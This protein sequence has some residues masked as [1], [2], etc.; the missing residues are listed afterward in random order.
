MSFLRK[1]FGQNSPQKAS[2]DE[3]PP[4]AP[5]DPANDPNLIRVYDDYGREIFITRNE[6]REKVLVGNIQKAWENPD[7]LYDI[8]LDA[9]N[10]NFRADIL[11]AAEQ[12][13]KIDPTPARGAC[14]W[15]IVL[16]EE[17]RFKEAQAIFEEHLTKHGADGVILTNLAKVYSKSGRGEKAEETLWQGLQIDP[18]QDNGMG[19]YEAIH[20]ERGGEDAGVEALRR[21]AAVPGSWRAYLSLARNALRQKDLAAAL[22]FYREA[23]SRVSPVP[24]DALMQISGDLG[25]NGYLIE[26]VQ[27]ITPLF[28]PEQHGLTVGNNLIKAHFD[29]GQLDVARQIL[30]Q[31]YALNRPDW[32]PHLDHWDTELAKA[33]VAADAVGSH[34]DIK[35][36]MILV[37]GPVWLKPT[38][39]GAGLFPTKDADAIGIAFLGGSAESPSRSQQVEYQMADAAGRLSRAVPLFLAEQ[40]EFLA[41][42]PTQNFVAR[43]EGDPG[44]FV[45]A[46]E[47]WADE[48]A[49][50]TARSGERKCDYVVNSHLKTGSEPWLGQLRLVRTIDGTCLGVVEAPIVP[51]DPTEGVDQLSR[52]LFSL[53]EQ[54]L[55]VKRISPPAAYQIPS[56]KDFPYYLLRLEQ[57]LAVRCSATDL[58][59]GGSA[60]L[61]GEREILA[62]NLQQC[63]AHSDSI[64][65][66]LLLAETFFVMKHVRPDILPEFHEKIEKLQ[67]DKPLPEPA[68]SVINGILDKAFGEE[69]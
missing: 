31:L 28:Q 33:R 3:Q 44:G 26:L 47:P 10:Q 17:G 63:L 29:L 65:L 57:L 59:Q 14:I 36:G 55:G 25:N 39:P 54:E 7:A 49:A 27:I 23:M 37:E 20:R 50:H 38:S 8:I 32:R 67:S 41:G 16:L 48:V 35:V 43:V 53:L 34:D 51:E 4:S 18:N 69:R 19:W 58:Y 11:P 40:V 64:S 5:A 15:G 24:A 42:V 9:L 62:G 21:V 22:A 45:L 61:S 1:L 66:R 68:S 13:Y 30:N 52:K 12:L 60:N 46:G 6:W 56:G 2:S